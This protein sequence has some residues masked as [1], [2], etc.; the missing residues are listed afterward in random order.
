VLTSRQLLDLHDSDSIAAALDRYRPWTVVNA[1]G[2]VRVDE[3]EAEPSAC[4]AVNTAGALTLA[5][6]CAARGIPCVQFSSDLVFDG[7]LDRPYL[8][9]DR[10]APLNAYGR[11]KAA[12]EGALN[13]LGGSHLIIRTAAFFS[14]FDAHNFAIHAVE[15]LA[16]D[17]PFAAAEDLVVTPTYVPD[18]CNAT[19]D[20]LIDGETGI[21]HLSN[22]EAVSWADFARRIARACGL[23]ANLVDGVSGSTLGWQAPRPRNAALA[24]ARGKLML[25]FDHVVERFAGVMRERGPRMRAMA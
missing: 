4:E 8:E 7:A 20:L 9:S 12:L 17:Q 24:S 22:G 13:A 18:L 19:M 25:P 16:A 10:P 3:A 2:W 21:W 15:A 14:P 11:S 5:R 6:A 1:A 23:D